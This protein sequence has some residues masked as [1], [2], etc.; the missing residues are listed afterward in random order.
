MKI[1]ITEKQKK[2]ILTESIGDSFELIIKENYELVKKVLK[3]ASEQMNLDLKFLLT[4]GASVGGFIGP[5]NDFVQGRFPEINELQ[6]SLIL[7]GV[8]A[9]YFSDN[10]EILFKLY[11][12]FKEEGILKTFMSVIK[13]TDELRDTFLTFVESLN[14]TLHKITNI[15]SYTFIIPLIPIIYNMA[16]EGVFDKEKITEISVRILGFG[17]MSVSGILV[18]ELISKMIKRFKN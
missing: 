15:I 11:E 8:I 13:K 18:K 7:T 16:M 5:I 9:T 1:L 14:L 10:K 3:N 6:L 17:L 4:W 2:R 12:K